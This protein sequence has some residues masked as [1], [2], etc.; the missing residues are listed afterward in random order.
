MLRAGIVELSLRGLGRDRDPLQRRHRGPLVFFGLRQRALEPSQLPVS[1]GELFLGLRQ[2]VLGPLQIPL[3]PCELS[4]GLLQRQPS[5]LLLFLCLVELPL[6]FVSLLLH[7]CEPA[8]VLARLADDL[9]P[10]L[11]SGH[12]LG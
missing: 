9:A 6:G 8:V 10:G 4:P 5:L 12:V 2:L 1:P 3:S 11:A 7:P